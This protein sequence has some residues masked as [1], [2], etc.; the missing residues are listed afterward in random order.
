MTRSARIRLVPAAAA[1]ATAALLC[2]PLP[3]ASADVGG[4]AVMY[5]GSEG[6]V[7]GCPHEV[8]FSLWQPVLPDTRLTIDGVEAGPLQP[9]PTGGYWVRWTPDRLGWHTIEV[10]NSEPGGR[11]SRRSLDIEVRRMGLNAGSSC[12]VNGFPLP[13]DLQKGTLGP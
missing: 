8:G 10:V 4:I 13:M 1:A 3:A 12:L 2:A 5:T 6:P 11:E 7:L 9:Y